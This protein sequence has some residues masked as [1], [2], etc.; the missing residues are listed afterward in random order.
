LARAVKKTT[1]DLDID[2]FK[3]LKQ[4]SL[5]TD[6]SVRTII[7]EAIAEK[8]SKEA[9]R[10]GPTPSTTRL[11]KRNPLADGI[12]GEL[13]LFFPEELAVRLLSQKCAE[14]GVVPEALRPSDISSSL[15]ESLARP[16][17]M[18][19][20][21]PRSVEFSRRIENLARGAR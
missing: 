16:V 15:V 19:S 3:R 6:R 5:D 8:L 11:I 20:P 1:I 10:D 21:G 14:H 18:M 12:L 2:L 4:Y 7:S 17:E 9:R 13:L